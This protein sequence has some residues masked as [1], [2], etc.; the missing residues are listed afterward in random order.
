MI[1][2]GARGNARA[3]FLPANLYRPVCFGQSVSAIFIDQS[4]SA[5]YQGAQTNF[6]PVL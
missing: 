6:E 3:Y 4:V 2:F 1:I 5:R